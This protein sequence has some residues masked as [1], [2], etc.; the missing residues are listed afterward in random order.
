[1]ARCPKILAAALILVAV[2]CAGH[3][4]RQKAAGAQHAAPL[5]DSAWEG[6]G[7][8]AARILADYIKVKS[9]NPPGA[10]LEAAR[11]LGRILEKEGIPFTIYESAP[12]RANLVARLKGD[13]SGKPILLLNH[14]DVV[15]ADAATWSVDPFGGVIKDGFVYGRGS[16]DMKGQGI[17]ELLAFIDAK[18]RG[19]KLKRD[20]IFLA[21]ADEEQGGRAGAQWMVD[22]HLG[23]V[24]AEF[25]LNEGGFGF[26]GFDPRLPP[27][28]LVAYAEKGVL[29]LRLRASGTAG[30]GSMP[31]KDNANLRLIRALD[32]VGSWERRFEV[33]VA[34][35][36]YIR[37]Q[38]RNKP[39]PKKVI[40]RM[41]GGLFY[42]PPVQAIISGK[43]EI[44]P[45]F[46][47]TVSI[48]VLKGGYKENVIPSDSEAI[49]DCRLLP[50]TSS[51]EFIRQLKAVIGDPK[52]D[53]EI[54]EWSE[55][56]ESPVNTEMFKAI[57]ATLKEMEPASVSVPFLFT[58]GTDSGTFRRKG[59]ASYGIAPYIMTP[60]D[61]TLA[62]GVDERLSIANLGRGVKFYTE[63]IKRVC[64]ESR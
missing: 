33:P 47:N 16:L 25:V 59:I 63:V 56:S 2:A 15:P 26:V 53:V 43:E 44:S 28:Y 20:I 8:E 36:Q 49:L 22:N 62:H 12:G 46:H 48:T 29:W 11:F 42:L 19:L 3:E 5:P 17:A 18:R 40:Y 10:E 35:K 4:T 1:M 24:D 7:Q 32:R 13:G 14:M 31:R 9:V 64:V 45:E 30:H 54:I 51:E 52:I 34:I 55:P 23:D 60:N 41:A 61:A 21:V 58:A 38:S 37:S 50:G 6:Q 27:I 39:L 57:G